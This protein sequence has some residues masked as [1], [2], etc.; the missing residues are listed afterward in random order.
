[1]NALAHGTQGASFIPLLAYRDYTAR[2]LFPHA[3]TTPVLNDLIVDADRTDAGLRQLNRLL[4]NS[5][6]LLSFMRT[7]DENKVSGEMNASGDYKCCLLAC[8]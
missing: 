8:F 3:P 7:I 5:S 2:V 4:L 1:M 6:F